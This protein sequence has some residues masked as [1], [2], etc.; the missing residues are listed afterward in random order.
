M[1]WP[2]TGS[3]VCSKDCGYLPCTM[4][5]RFLWCSLRSTL[6]ASSSLTLRITCVTRPMKGPIFPLLEPFEV[7]YN[8]RHVLP[9]RSRSSSCPVDSS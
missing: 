7:L 1:M 5:Q 9:V 8:R 4:R 6:S 3:V 2:Q